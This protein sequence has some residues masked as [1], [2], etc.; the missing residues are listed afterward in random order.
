[1]VACRE[2]DAFGALGRFR[3]NGPIAAHPPVRMRRIPPGVVL[4]F[5]RWS[6]TDTPEIAFV[7][8]T[9]FRLLRASG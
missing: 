4:A 2:V 9:V 5:A 1:L 6:Q 7:P 3:A 8:Y